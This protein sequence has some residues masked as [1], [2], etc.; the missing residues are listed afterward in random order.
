MKNSVVHV[1]VSGFV[2]NFHS[3]ISV[4]EFVMLS[5]SVYIDG[6]K[7]HYEYVYFTSEYI[8]RMIDIAMDC[9]T[10]RD[11]C[12]QFFELSFRAG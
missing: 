9:V 10:S 1:F 11:P 12:Q 6:G 8:F 2:L 5:L 7:P 4:T 3:I